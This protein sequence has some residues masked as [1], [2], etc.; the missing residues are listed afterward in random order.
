MLRCGVAF[1]FRSC[2]TFRF[3]RAQ[4]STLFIYRKSLLIS[5]ENIYSDV[6]RAQKRVVRTPHEPR[7]R[8]HTTEPTSLGSIYC[9]LGCAVTKNS[10][11]N[12]RCFIAA[13][14]LFYVFLKRFLFLSVRPRGEQIID[15]AL[16]IIYRKDALS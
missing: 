1:F 9:S 12:W 14:M 8:E 5:I 15:D 7:N 6:G 3:L 11:I 4:K 2:L 16:F 10:S 13:I